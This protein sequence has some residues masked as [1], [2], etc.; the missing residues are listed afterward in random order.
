[1]SDSSMSRTVSDSKDD[2]SDTHYA[3]NRLVLFG[4]LGAGVAALC[5]FTPLLVWVFA[6]LGLAGLTALI[7]IVLLPLLGIALIAVYVGVRQ[8]RRARD[9]CA[10]HCA[11]PDSDESDH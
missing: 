3:R 6:A 1:M 4:G 11:P 9:A 7:D 10:D 8:V 5:C 2:W